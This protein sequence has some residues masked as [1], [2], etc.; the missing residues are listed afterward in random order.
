MQLN[1]GA[2]KTMA[3]R[4]W[5]TCVPPYRTLFHFTEEV[6]RLSS[7]PRVLDELRAQLPGDVVTDDPD[8]MEK[9]RRDRADDPCAGTPLAVV[10]AESTEHVQCALRWASRH[11][12]A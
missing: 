1:A 8:R 5:M 12:V 9:Y 6:V 3:P 2:G 7:M 11:R 10:R 4:S